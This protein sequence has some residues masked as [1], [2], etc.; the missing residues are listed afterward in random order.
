MKANNLHSLFNAHAP[1]QPALTLATIAGQANEWFFLQGVPGCTKARRAPSCLIIP[2]IGDTVLVCDTGS[3][4]SAY[5]LS[6]LIRSTPAAATL[7]LPGGA[8]LTTES[9][10]LE[11]NAKVIDLTATQKMKFDAPLL[12][13]EASK[14][15]LRV[16]QIVGWFESIESHALK[17]SVVAKA[18][19]T[20][21]GR[22]LQQVQD[23]FRWIENNDETRAG[24]VRTKVK[25]HYLVQTENAS[26]HAEGM[27]R[28]NGEKIDLG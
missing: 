5:V 21:V 11:V 27:V 7:G 22:L 8:C 17:V 23:S 25:G 1:V 24:R 13:V 15:E 14:T 2:E 6:V 10:N 16:R 9:G 12:C 18:M 3:E 19:T 26:I 28:I 20:K 4:V